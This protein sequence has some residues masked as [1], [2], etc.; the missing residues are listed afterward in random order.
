MVGQFQSPIMTLLIIKVL[1]VGVKH[2]QAPRHSHTALTDSM[3]ASF[4]S[5]DR[6]SW[7]K[8]I[9]LTIMIEQ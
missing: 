8:L 2:R 7:H 3:L 1:G 5:R 6:S 4:V 9:A